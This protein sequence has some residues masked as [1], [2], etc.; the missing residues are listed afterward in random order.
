MHVR[1]QLCPTLCDTTDGS[2]QSTLSMGFP[3][4]DDW[5]QLPFPPSEDLP[6][7]GIEPVSPELSLGV[8]TTE[9]SGEP[10]GLYA[11]SKF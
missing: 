9:P 6:N 2:R 1:A 4:Q 8:F 7:L 5:S 10:N 11:C 3:R